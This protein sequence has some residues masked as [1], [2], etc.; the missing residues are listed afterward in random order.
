MQEGQ[1]HEGQDGK[2]REDRWLAGIDEV[3]RGPIA[4]PVVAAA[5]VFPPSL[6]DAPPCFLK[7]VRDSKQLSSSVRERLAGSITTSAFVGLG[8]ASVAEIE[9]INILQASLRAMERA[10]ARLCG[11]LERAQGRGVDVCLVDGR[12]VPLLVP[13]PE[14]VIAVVRGD[15]KSVT[16]ACASI[17][18]KVVRDRLM[19][20][21]GV[22]Y[23]YYGWGKNRGYGVAKHLEAVG[24][25]GLSPHHRRTFAP[26]RALLLKQTAS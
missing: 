4:G 17:V 8:A 9:R 23:P 10:F 2:R 15:T 18:A 1:Q 20:R 25:E 6:F 12:D 13:V 19:E 5:V 11:T 22:R 24:A 3:G 7:Q 21:L 26:C 16:I 14:E